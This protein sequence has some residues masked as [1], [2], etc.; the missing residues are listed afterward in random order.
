[1]RN[2]N[3][4]SSVKHSKIFNY[5]KDKCIDKYG[6]VYD[7]IPENFDN[8]IEVVVDWGEPQCWCCGRIIPVEEEEKYI[9]WLSDDCD[10]GLFKIWDCK[11]LRH[12]VDRAHIKPNM[13]GG[14]DIPS[15]LFLLCRKCHRK[16]PDLSNPKMFLAYIYNQRTK[17]SSYPLN[18]AAEAITILKN[19]YNIKF[20]VFNNCYKITLPGQ[21]GGDICEN[22]YL[23]QL[24]S[25]AIKNK[26]GLRSD[27]EEMFRQYLN[28]KISE[29]NDL[30][31]SSNDQMEK[32]R[33]NAKLDV[34]NEVLSSYETFK[35]IENC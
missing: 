13:L 8:T 21:H 29:I 20:P 6:N 5:W 14:E 16:T 23:Y 24:I 35:T 15:N 22:T 27:L 30:I 26:T 10:E 31:N 12:Y 2:R 1:M 34:Y 28:T 17:N 11:T 9:D 4:G 7:N 33:L 19:T 3:T 32:D 18:I 25:A